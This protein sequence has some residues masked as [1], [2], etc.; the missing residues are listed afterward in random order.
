METSMTTGLVLLGIIILI[1]II[2]VIVTPY[3]GF[4]NLIMELLLLDWLGDCLG[5]VLEG[6]GDI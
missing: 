2:R 1:G 5:G 3:T 6:V 4:V